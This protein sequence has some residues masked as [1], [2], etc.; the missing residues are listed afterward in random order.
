MRGMAAHVYVTNDYA[1]KRHTNNLQVSVNSIVSS[2]KILNMKITGF[3]EEIGE[4]KINDKRHC[5]F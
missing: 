5:L 2:M 1:K 3:K 4:K